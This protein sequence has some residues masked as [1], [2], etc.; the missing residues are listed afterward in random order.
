MCSASLCDGLSRRVFYTLGVICYIYL[1]ILLM[2]TCDFAKEESTGVPH[3]KHRSQFDPESRSALQCTSLI[4]T[5]FYALI[6]SALLTY[7]KRSKCSDAHDSMHVLIKLLGRCCSRVC[8]FIKQVARTAAGLSY[9]YLLLYLHSLNLQL[10]VISNPSITNP[11]PKKLSVLYNNVQGF[12]NTRDLT[13]N[14]PP[15][16]MTK[17]HE[18]NGYIFS[19]RPDIIL[20]NE[21]WL[22]RSILSKEIFPDSYKL[23]RIDRS[24]KTHPYDPNRPKKF[25]KNGGGVLIA[26]RSDL[27]ITS[28]KF[29]KINV[30]AE[31]LSVTFKTK[32]GKTFCLSTFYR[33]GTLGSENF[34][35]FHKH[36]TSLATSRKLGKHILIGDFNFP[37][38]SWPDATTSCE[39]HGK[40]LD[41]LIGDLGHTQL[42]T[43]PTHKSGHILDLFFTNVPSLI[44]NLKVLDQN[45]FCLSDHQAISFDIEIEVKYKT[46][47]KRKV[48]NYNNGDYRAL[49]EDLSNVNWD[50]AFS[51]NDPCQAWNIFKNIL[52][53]LCERRIPKKTIRSQFQPPWY[54]SDCDRIRRK[55]EKWRIKA[56]EATNEHDCEIFTERFRLARKLFKKTLNDKL[57]LNFVDDSD[58][59]LIS[60]RFWTHVK[61]KSK[62]TRIPETVKYCNR[63]RSD[64]KDQA[65]LFNEYFYNQFSEASDYNIDID[66]INNDFL[67]LQFHSEDIFNILKMLN[68]NKA[69][70]PD[71]IHGKVLKS[72]ARSLAYPLSI[73]F[74]LSFVTGCIPQDWKLASVVPVFKKG[75][76]SSV[77]NYRPISLTSL[78][79][80]VFERCIKTA[81]Y[82]VCE[83]VLDPRQHGFLNNRSCVTQMIPFLH[84]LATNLNDKTRSDIIYFDFAKAFD[85]VSHDLILKKLKENFKVD[86]LMLR[87]IRAYLEGREQQVVIGGHT[88]SKLP[89]RSGVPQGSILGPLLFVLFINDMFSSVTADTNIALYADDTKIWR[90]IT[91]YSDHFILQNDINNLFDWSVRNRMVFHPSKCKA[92]SVT[93][94][95]NAL[96]NLPFN[97]F[98]YEINGTGIDYVDSQKD[99][100]VMINTNLTW[101]PHYNMLVP[102]A[103]SKLGLLRRTCHF[104]T[105]LRQ[106]RSFYLAIVRSLFEHCSPIWSPQYVTHLVRFENIQKSAIKWING[107]PFCSY[108]EEKYAEELRKLKILPMRLKFLYNDLVL[109]YKIVNR[110]V[111][112]DFPDSITLVNV[113]GTRLTRR[114]AAVLD[115]TDVTRYSCSI[116]P[117]TDVLRNSFFLRTVRNWNSLPVNVR[118]SISITLFKSSLM[119]YMW[120]PDVVWPD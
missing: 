104:T 98:Y 96:D 23:F 32:C 67:D 44:K 54:D 58:P 103:S 55:K 18:M 9:I 26:C 68:A 10:I 97:V 69:A 116:S 77:E 39:L 81:L 76:K 105:S 83:D 108:S 82:S 94:Q 110:L 29:S 70:G 28:C 35:E 53:Q 46:S 91:Q 57:K 118:Q 120:S 20:L 73:L 115:L 85:S 31:V 117:N 38:V 102:Q 33:V 41:F 11:G 80:K 1:L 45:A 4:N 95:R 61:S 42:I 87:F 24:T 7:L 34:D 17:V 84:D 92:L 40:F 107:E 114:N 71:G 100:G 99:L 8:C 2:L 12:I 49:N 50:R 56:K 36:I 64:P 15:L 21:T 27:D 78:V 89:V 13:S 88:S 16:N 109:F 51:C 19:N 43:T 5:K 47:P 119:K 3:F 113:E 72:C 90:R 65:N 48:F 59:A 101:G 66:F 22:K 112:I 86:G 25:R 6:I 93:M 75:D 14:S 74:N 52:G 63:F 79:M 62:S 60:K 37:E 106:K 111:P 30:Q